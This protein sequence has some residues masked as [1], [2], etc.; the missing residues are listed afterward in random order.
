MEG[1][2]TPQHLW[3]MG[4]DQMMHQNPGHAVVAGVFEV[5]TIYYSPFCT[6]SQIIDLQNSFNPSSVCVCGGGG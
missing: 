6:C 2:R 4:L 5:G 1:N 3:M